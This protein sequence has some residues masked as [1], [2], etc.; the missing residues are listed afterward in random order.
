[1]GNA[2]RT[3]VRPL[4]RARMIRSSVR[5]PGCPVARMRK[6]MKLKSVRQRSIAPRPTSRAWR[7]RSPV[8][9]CPNG[10]AH[11]PLSNNR[12]PPRRWHKPRRGRPLRGGQ[13]RSPAVSSTD[14]AL[15]Q[16]SMLFARRAAVVTLRSTNWRRQ[17]TAPRNPTR[18][19]VDRAHKTAR[20]TQ[21]TGQNRSAIAPSASA[22]A[23]A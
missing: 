13:S 2:R 4:K 17:S 21:Q 15:D 1:M 19:K 5:L 20:S 10:K 8:N 12:P 22:T 23:R 3:W 7:K 9:A 14:E 18:Q 6:P 11:P 16:S